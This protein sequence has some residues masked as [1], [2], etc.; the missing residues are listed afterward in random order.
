MRR[1]TSEHK[2]ARAGARHGIRFKG[3]R[4]DGLRVLEASP[5]DVG[6]HHHPQHSLALATIAFGL[7]SAL[8]AFAGGLQKALVASAH[9][10]PVSCRFRHKLGSWTHCQVTITNLLH[11]SSAKAMVLNIRDVTDRKQMEE[12]L[13][14]LASHDPVTGLPNRISFRS[15]VDEA[16]ER[17]Q[18]PSTRPVTS[19][20]HGASSSSSTRSAGR[21]PRSA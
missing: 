20:G 21:P 9:P 2:R 11:Q 14:H 19:R 12:R 13:T 8:S 18:R 3:W 7:G 5:G 17:S 10:I 16:L 6:F 15:Q 1:V 4:G